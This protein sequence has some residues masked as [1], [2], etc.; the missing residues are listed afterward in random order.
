MAG[1]PQLRAPPS[2]VS[3]RGSRSSWGLGARGVL[4]LMGSWSMGVLVPGSE[5][6]SA[7]GGLGLFWRLE[8]Q[9]HIKS[10]LCTK[11]SQL[12]SN[13]IDKP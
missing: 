11:T 13:A 2:R 3:V 8:K 1:G 10:G 5:A 7:G 6:S 12:P 9:S 4:E